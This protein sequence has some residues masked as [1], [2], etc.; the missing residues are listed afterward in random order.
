MSVSKTK[1]FVKEV[2]AILKGDDA[3]ATGQKILRQADSAF[4][5]QI[6][7]LTGDTISLE[8]AVEEAKEAVRLARLNN[9]Q[10]IGNRNS[11]ISILLSAQNRLVE[12][13][14]ALEAH[15]AKLAFLNEQAELLDA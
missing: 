3:E 13:E 6:A 7:S 4:K 10:L 15:L 8:D 12:A 9:G 1:S 2:I 14:E 11:Y 5:T